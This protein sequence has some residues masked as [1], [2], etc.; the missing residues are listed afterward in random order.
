MALRPQPHTCDRAREWVS[1]RLDDEISELE[2]ALLEAH[3]RRCAAC[4][5]YEASV[6]G[7][8]VALRARP[9]ERMDQ[10][11]VVS[12]RRRAPLRPAAVARVAAVVAAVVGVT[13]VLS[14]QAAKGPASHSSNTVPVASVPDDQDLKQLRTLRV[15]QLGGRP[16]RGTGIG[17]YGV[18]AGAPPT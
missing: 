12:R 6:R 13:T 18:N 1:L 17:S 4:R 11:I 16:P 15:L 3:L 10:P 5:E 7:A 2:D 8:V 14:T 9:L